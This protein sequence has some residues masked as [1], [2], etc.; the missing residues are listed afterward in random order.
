MMVAAANR[1]LSGDRA[2]ELLEQVP[3]NI[4]VIAPDFSVVDANGHFEEYFGDWQG[5]KCYEIYKGLSKPC[6][7]CQARKA[8]SDGLV[9]V[10]DE[11][12]HDRHGRECHYV[13]HLVPMRNEAGEVTHVVEMSTDLTATARWQREYNLLFE[14]VPCYVA[15]LDR[16]RKIVRA[17]E[18][19]RETFGEAA[20][21]FCYEVYKK[22]NRPCAKC[23]A[24]AAFADGNQHVG[25]QVGRRKDGSQAHYVM[26]AAPLARDTDGIAHVIEIATDITEMRTLEGE[27]RQ[28]HDLHESLVK[29]L[30]SAVLVTD[31]AGKVQLINPFGRELLGLTG[32]RPPS[33]K[34]LREMLPDFYFAPPEDEPTVSEWSEEKVQSRTGDTVPVLFRV[35]ELFS[36]KKRLGRAAY[37]RDLRKIKKLEK[38]KLE[39]ER[40]AAVGHTVAGL[41]H[42]IKNLLMGLEGGMYM[43]DTGMHKG[44]AERIAE[45]WEVL[46]LNFDKTTKL[47]K[48]F[49]SFA[50]GRLPS[51]KSTDPNKLVENI[52]ALY[53]DTAAQ[54]GVT[55]VQ[56]PAS[57]I[58]ELPLDPDGIEACLTNL[59]SNGMDAVILRGHDDGKVILKTRETDDDLIFEVVDNGCG[60]DWEVKQK[61]F[62]T[63]FTTKGGEGTGL[64]LLTTRKIIQE[65]GGKIEVE[66]VPEVGSTF[67]I[68]LPKAR[69]VQLA[70]DATGDSA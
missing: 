55:L 36:G 19:F 58:G 18:R 47:V 10:S 34:K 25:T 66:T 21:R 57:N 44:D 49:L 20:G 6:P 30:A 15:I 28:A 1:I 33:S 59:V 38:D 53:A 2:A 68:R 52:V 23:P 24:A 22:K 5:R 60:M 43:V 16:D 8:F 42:T 7:D 45:G 4:A 50:K 13:V 54:Q 14:R 31:D 65:H 40:L 32:V 56:E 35:A 11:S 48:D 41:A 37:I 39:A 26:T 46:Q 70:K 27:L 61:V 29:N 64:G 69:L 9:R 67:R 12:G 63:F 17:N 3:F 62:T 51:L